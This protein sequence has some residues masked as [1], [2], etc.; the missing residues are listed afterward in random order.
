AAITAARHSKTLRVL[1]FEQSKQTLQ[2]V[3][4]SGGGRCNV[5]HACFDPRE[6]CASY[7]RGHRNLIGPF[8]HWGPADTV[9]WFEELGVALKTESDGRMFP[10]SDSSQTIIDCL[11][12]EAKKQDVEVHLEHELREARQTGD[13]SFELAFSRKDPVSCHFLLVA[14]GGIRN[15]TGQRIGT[16]F[17][18]RVHPAAP[19]LFTF[20]IDHPLLRDLPGLSVGDA[21]I[22]VKG[23]RNLDSSGPLLIT[24]WGLSGPAVLKLSSRGARRFQEWDYHFTIHVNWMGRMTET[25]LRHDLEDHRLRH[26]RKKVANERPWKSLPLR[27]WQRMV[28]LATIDPELSWTHLSRD[29]T[30]ELL[31]ILTQTK[32]QVTGKSMNKEEFVTCGGIDLNEVNLKTME[33]KRV[34][35]L[36]FA[37]ET[38]DIDGITG[39]FNFQAAWTTGRLAG[40]TIAER[41]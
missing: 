38:L 33:S 39:G 9:S 15:G 28:R 21:S 36:F 14:S 13:Q 23:E 7:P 16:G 6:L 3:R 17:G 20:K 22:A 12:K 30:L 2:K 35:N 41:A 11:T 24:H 8:H 19:S 25:T 1:I 34:P 27:L 18:H 37:G 4:I 10:V 32:L 29:S 5:T 26:P 40:E 31:T